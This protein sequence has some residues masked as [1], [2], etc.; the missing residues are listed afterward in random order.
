MSS[1][2]WKKRSAAACRLSRRGS[3]VHVRLEGA[4]DVLRREHGER[5]LEFRG[6]APVV[7]DQAVGLLVALRAVDAGDGLEQRVFLERGV[8]I[9]D[10]L[11]RGVEAGQQHVAD[12]Q[13]G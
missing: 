11:D 12:D 3:S 5:V 10:L 4:P 9:H 6:D 13:D 1:T 7:H 8:Q 2:D